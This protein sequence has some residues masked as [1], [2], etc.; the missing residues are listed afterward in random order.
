[1]TSPSNPIRDRYVLI[2]TND[3]H[4]TTVGKGD[5]YW[6]GYVN[7]F[8]ELISTREYFPATPSVS[9][10]RNENFIGGDTIDFVWSV[11]DP[12]DHDLIVLFEDN[13]YSVGPNGYYRSIVGRVEAKADT[14]SPERTQIRV[15]SDPDRWWVAYVLID[16]DGNQRILRTSHGVQG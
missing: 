9:L 7:H 6:V 8:G 16:D 5:D 3:I 14:N 4:T 2:D 12:G 10:R 1:M 15:G 13:P 11:S